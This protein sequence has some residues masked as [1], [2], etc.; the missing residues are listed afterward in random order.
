MDIGI[1]GTNNKRPLD[2]HQPSQNL[3]N[4]RRSTRNEKSRNKNDQL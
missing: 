1:S 3:N 4:T 2:N